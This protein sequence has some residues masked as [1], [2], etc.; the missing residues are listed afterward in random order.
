MTE[1][2]TA[3]IY[4]APGR[5][6]LRRVD[7]PPLGPGAVEVETRF[8]ALS[9]GTERLV[10][11]GRVPESERER[12]RAPFQEGDFPFP[13]KY[14]YA[15][16]GTVVAGPDALL[17]RDVFALHPHQDRF[18]VPAGA[19]VPLPPDVPA[20]RAVLGAN[21]ETALNALWDAEPLSGMRVLVVGAGLLGSLVAMFLSSLQDVAVTVTDT[22]EETGAI[23]ADFPVK[24]RRAG[25]AG[26]DYDLV[27]HSSA[28]AE[29]L[30][31]ALD[32]LAFEGTCIELSWYGAGAVPVPLGGAFHARRLTLK[33]SQVGHVAPSRRTT[34]SRAERLA[35]AIG[36][37]ADPRLDRLVTE[38]VAFSDLPAAIP[39]LLAP[40]AP[41]IATRVVY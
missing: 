39:R 20:G 30:A 15:A 19:V 37:L 38:Q 29:G 1:H 10:A 6:E 24:F 21:A 25:E 8:S 17:G 33:A 26:G 2:A 40:D 31:T 27:F 4:V 34:T 35:Q 9:R 11:A 36:R 7:L 22:V 5:A 23:F 18:R 28:S 32:A 14:G 13:V 12:M 3:L 16:A 41:G